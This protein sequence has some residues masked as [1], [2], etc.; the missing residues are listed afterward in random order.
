MPYPQLP[1]KTIAA[2]DI[3]TNSAH[4]VVA[5]MDHVGEMRILDSD[6]VNLRLGQAI[7]PDGHL[8]EDGIRRTVEA[9]SHMQEIIKPFGATTRAVA[10]HA[11]REAKN[12]KRLLREIEQT[13]G[14]NVELIDGIEE[15]RLVFLGMRYGLSLNNINCLGVDVG[16]G[17]TE[18]IVARDDD[19]KF[20][21]SVKLGAVTLTDRYFKKDYSSAGCDALKEHVHSR[22]APLQ[23]ET[24]R[25]TYERTLASS[26][27]AKALAF[28]HA[29][30]FANSVMS[31][32]NGY[33]LPRD[34]LFQ[35]SDQF[36]RLL[37]PQKIRD[38][39]GL[40]LARAEIILAGTVILEEL[41]HL[42][43]VKEWV[44]TSFGLR[45][46]LVAD[47]FYRA[48]EAPTGELPDIQWHSVLQFARRLGLNEAHAKQVKSLSLK[49]YSQLSPHCLKSLPAETREVD[50]KLLKAASYLRE[51]GKFIST[52]QYHRHSQYLISNSRLPGFT[53]SERALMG[54]IGRFQRKGM[55]SSDHSDCIDL[56][57]NDIKRLRF[58]A[59]VVRLAAA[60][61]RTRQERVQDIEL[62]I[63]DKT[64][65]IT[66]I[67]T[68]ANPPDVE[69]HKA[70]L[71][72]QALEK[73]WDLA[74]RFELRAINSIETG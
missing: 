65:T 26:G 39:T 3:G 18:I 52:P 10:T 16:G 45:E 62:K 32:P 31:D 24:K 51:A 55:P 50:V 43:K 74:I 11:T 17:S 73:S 13:S 44:I 71:E 46:G 59:A 21:S 68:V 15:A 9:L 25:F 57:T 8:S 67:H 7:S 1:K 56:N 27:T 28:L 70:R 48:S 42:L 20:V 35:I 49:I 2:I 72:K 64:L 6:K 5:E 63:V 12:H 66:L 36:R 19:I 30:M 23:Q 38:A 60:L 58:L 53:E 14:I 34:D 41:T 61:D 40:D 4:M 37:S 47:T 54:L 69:L 22:L 29:R 33:I